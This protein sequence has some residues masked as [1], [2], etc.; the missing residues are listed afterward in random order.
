MT[1]MSPYSFTARKARRLAQRGLSLVELMVGL[2]IGL[3]LTLGLFTLI[4]SQS[5]AF[6]TQDDFARMQENGAT[7]LRYI[8]DSVRMAGFYGYTN[9][10]ATVDTIVGGVNTAA[11]GDCGSATN[12]PTT[13]WA[14]NVAVP[15]YGFPDDGSTG[16]TSANVNAILPCILAANFLDA[17]PR[18]QQVLITRSAGGYRIPDTAPVGD[19]TA[20]LAAQPNYATTVYL[21][22]D[23]NGGLLFY[24]N[25]FAALKALPSPPTRKLVLP[26]G[27]VIDVDIFEYRVHVYYLRP[28]SRPAPPPV[29]DGVNCT[30]AGD[31]AGHPIPTLVRQ[32][33]VGSAMTQVPLVEGI[34][35]IDFHYGIDTSGDGV[36]HTF[37]ASPTAADWANVVAVKVSVLVRSPTLS[38]QQDD[39]A[40][41]YDLNGDGTP[42]YTCTTFLAADPS[43]CNYKRKVF[44]QIFQLRN[45]AQRRGA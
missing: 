38:A 34:E 11:G 1:T 23:P 29:G 10:P 31:D 42:D 15:V 18:G 44:S 16:L 19:L 24:G 9:D 4:S 20:D 33:L 17:L 40:K 5:S 28:C 27:T 37:K 3:V 39:S 13:N 26:N 6:K 35:R 2:A 12:L 36:V 32:E 22:A 45:I 7:A 14:L 8:G 43:A 21:Q 25:N 41:S 30:G